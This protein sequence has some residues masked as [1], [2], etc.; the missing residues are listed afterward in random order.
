MQVLSFINIENKR[1]RAMNIILSTLN[2]KYIHTNIALR[3]LKSFAMPEYI[4]H[5][6]EYT[7]KDPTMNIVSDLSK[8]P[9]CCRLQPLYLEY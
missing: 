8:K 1:R 5:I 4:P 7:I 3:Y 2:A 9:G 6:A